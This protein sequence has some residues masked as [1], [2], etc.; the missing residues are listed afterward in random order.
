MEYSSISKNLTRALSK[1]EKRAG[2]I[3]FTPPSCVRNN[4]EL[5]KP[6]IQSMR[7][8]LEPSCGSGEYIT[9]F[10]EAFPSM[11]ITGVEYNKTIYE[12]VKHLANDK[13]AILNQDYLSSYGTEEKFDLIIGNPPYFVMRKSEVAK[14][15]HA[16][17]DGRPNIFILFI[18][19]SLRLLSDGGILSF[20][21]PTNF[22]NCIYYDKTRRYIAKH[23]RILNIVDCK[24]DKYIETQQDTTIVIIQKSKSIPRTSPFVIE[25]ES[26]TIFGDKDKNQKISNLYKNS[27]TLSELGF[28][29]SVGN[30]VWNQCKGV[31]TDDKTKTRLIYS[32]DVEGG[33]LVMKTYKNC[34]KK[35]YIIKQG[36]RHPM[37]VVNRGYG[38]GEYK[39]N[40]CL[41]ADIGEYLVENHLICITRL[42]EA[43]QDVVIADYKKILASLNDTRT[44]EFIKLYFGNSAINTTELAHML[45]MYQDI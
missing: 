1:H 11:S 36:Y 37:I 33:S 8:M 5:L 10:H 31:L 19:K 24:S 7:N 4:I 6:Y 42:E 44:T 28:G 3:Y 14:E 35:N 13:I 18:I 17:F 21:L 12:D 27:K 40:C 15:Y 2:G 34:D 32:S 30:V 16:Y 29:V 22:L 23:F 45:P 25:I 41:V 39:F 26:Y 38:V 20:V 43:T 9:A